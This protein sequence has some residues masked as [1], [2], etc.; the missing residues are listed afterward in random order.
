[1][2]DTHYLCRVPWSGILAIY[3]EK[4]YRHARLHESQLY[5]PD[6][7]YNLV[8]LAQ[9]TKKQMTMYYDLMGGNNVI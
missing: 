3:P 7:A 6:E 5:V 8:L 4:D 1:M 9:G 2:R